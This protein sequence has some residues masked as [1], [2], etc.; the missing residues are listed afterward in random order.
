MC[1]GLWGAHYQFQNA[2]TIWLGIP[3]IFAPPHWLRSSNMMTLLVMCTRPV[4][5]R[6]R[7]W[8]PATHTLGWVGGSLGVPWPWLLLLLPL[9]PITPIPVPVSTWGLVTG[10]VLGWEGFPCSALSFSVRCGKTPTGDRSFCAGCLYL[11]ISWGVPHAPC[12]RLGYSLSVAGVLP[13]F[14]GPQRS[15]VFVSGARATK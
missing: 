13:L 12:H 8:P 14:W 4:V 9:L 5:L 1:T 11:I 15:C 6:L 3:N 10:S 2:Q 7:P